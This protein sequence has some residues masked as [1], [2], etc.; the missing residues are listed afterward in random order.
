MSTTRLIITLTLID[1]ALISLIKLFRIIVIVDTF[2][3]I[4]CFVSGFVRTVMVCRRHGREGSPTGWLIGMF[5]GQI[6]VVPKLRNL[7]QG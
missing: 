4:N 7:T 5:G 6:H 3:V 1:C 2:F